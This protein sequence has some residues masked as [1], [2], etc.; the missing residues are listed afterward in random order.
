MWLQAQSSPFLQ[1]ATLAGTTAG[2]FVD[3]PFA[4]F[5]AYLPSLAFKHQ[6][7]FRPT[8]G[9]TVSIRLHHTLLADAVV[10]AGIWAAFALGQQRFDHAASATA[11]T[12]ASRAHAHGTQPWLVSSA[13]AC[14]C[15]RGVLL[16]VRCSV[17]AARRTRSATACTTRDRITSV[18]LATLRPQPDSRP[19]HPLQRSILTIT[20]AIPVSVPPALPGKRRT[21]VPS[22]LNSFDLQRI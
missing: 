20:S 2:A 10:F 13:S 19:L 5:D 14:C 12:I 7:T 11:T 15:V 9:G 3:L 22:A 4:S 16:S 17:L 8:F 21:E 1:D 18:R 6:K